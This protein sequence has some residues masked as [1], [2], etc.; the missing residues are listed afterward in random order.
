M[1]KRRQSLLE[2]V[3]EEYLRSGE[4]IGSQTLKAL[5]NFSISSATIR[6][7][8]KVMMDMG[9]LSQ[10]H[11]SSGRIP[12]A[13]ALKDYWRSH[14]ELGSCK[15]LDDLNQLQKISQEIGCFASY[16]YLEELRLQEVQSYEEKFLILKFSEESEVILRYSTHLARFLNDLVGMSLE[17][18]QSFSHQVCATELLKTLKSISQKNTFYGAKFLAS[19]MEENRGEKLFF[20]M[21][22]GK[23]FSRLSNG[24]YFEDVLPKGY[25]LFIQDVLIEGKRARVLFC[26]ALECNYLKTTSIWK[27]E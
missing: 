19:F 11:I 4:P 5:G 18:I 8:F 23:I 26:G 22:E 21:I 16:L 20:E 17:D 25:V 1:S 3:I 10:P 12:T 7:H 15:K 13:I 9:L 24:I 27:G 2:S 6:N 14:L